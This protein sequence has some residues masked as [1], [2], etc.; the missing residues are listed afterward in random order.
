[1]NM[2]YVATPDLGG[3]FLRGT[4]GGGQ[5]GWNIDAYRRGSM[6]PGILG[7]IAGTFQLDSI[8]EHNHSATGTTTVTSSLD[9]PRLVNA[10][11]IGHAKSATDD[12]GH[13]WGENN[14]AVSSSAVTVV[15]IGYTGSV[16]NRPVYYA[17]NYVIKY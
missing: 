12:S 16:E 4:G 17:V 2:M 5:D 10:S 8:I 3:L 6:V 14:V 1:M 15:T 9:I 13:D 11:G 7:D